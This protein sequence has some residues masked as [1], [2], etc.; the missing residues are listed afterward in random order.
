MKEKIL[1]NLLFD[2]IYLV[3]LQ[4]FTVDINLPNPNTDL[5]EKKRKLKNP[6]NSTRKQYY[7]D[8]QS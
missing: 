3:I 7:L 4:F 5:I 1:V 2:L 8:Q 6:I